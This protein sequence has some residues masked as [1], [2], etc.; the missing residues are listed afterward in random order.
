V[1]TRLIGCVGTS[2][3]EGKKMGVGSR[4]GGKRGAYKKLLELDDL[5]MQNEIVP[6]VV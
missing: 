1:F 3:R 4:G 6:E 2:Q 5:R